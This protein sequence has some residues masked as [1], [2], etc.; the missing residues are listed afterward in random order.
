MLTNLKNHGRE[1]NHEESWRRNH[2]KRNHREG[3]IE[4]GIWEA[5]GSIREASET[6]RHLAGSQRL[7]EV[8]GLQEA[9]NHKNRAGGS[10]P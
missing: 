2:W 4:E 1:I 8:R 6:E 3:I 5:T 9:P 10:K 7:Q